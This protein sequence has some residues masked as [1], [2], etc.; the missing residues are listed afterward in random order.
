MTFVERMVGAARL[1]ARV[2]EEVEADSTATPQAL[3]VVVLASV[4]SGLAVGDGV[5]GLVVGTVAG[6][7]GW[8][9]WA[10]LVYFIGTRW[11][12]EPGTRADVGELLRVIGFATSPGILRVIGIVP[13]L[14]ALVLAVTAVWTL[15]A[16]VVAA[17]QALDYASTGRAVGVCLIGWLVQVAIFALLGLALSRPAW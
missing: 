1:D 16:V 3:A 8:V 17:R 11:L 12:P 14:S 9:V 4:A 6:L 2:F 7:V 13:F 10:W 15:V 5:R